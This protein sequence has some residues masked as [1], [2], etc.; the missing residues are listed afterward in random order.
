MSAFGDFIALSSEVDEPTAKIISREVSDGVIAPSYS[1]VAL[2]ILSK[3]KGGK[4]LV[5]QMSTTYTPPARESRSV[6][7]VHLE[8][9]RNDALI[10]PNESFNAVMTCKEK[11]LTEDAKRDLTVATIALKYTQSNS[12]CFASRGQVVGLGAGQQSRIH[13]TRLAGSK[14]DNFHMRFHPR[15]LEIQWKKGTKRPDK[16][17]ALDMLCSGSVPKNGIELSDWEKNFEVVPKIFEEKE[18][19]EWLAGMKGVVC[20]SDAFFPFID[21]VFRASQSGCEYIAAPTG[22]QNDGV[23]METAEKLGIVFCEQYVRL[24]YTSAPCIS[25][26]V[27]NFG[28]RLFHH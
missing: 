17:N 25:V 12:V 4:Y 10:T 3:K 27:A 22:S 26:T 14:A 1:Q 28:I 6:Y 15:S 24:V 13:C 18:R 16:A 21:N 2:D 20:S 8:Q 9:T 5:L 23:V 19:E 11:G 7:G